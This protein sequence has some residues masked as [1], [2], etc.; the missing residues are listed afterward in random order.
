[1][2]KLQL[3]E[4][5]ITFLERKYFEFPYNYFEIWKTNVWSYPEQ[6]TRQSVNWLVD[7]AVL[8]DHRVRVK[9]IKKQKTEKYLNFPS[10]LKK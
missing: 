2:Q 10:E 9:K 4:H 1:M 5:I 6:K 7:F 8:P 3:F